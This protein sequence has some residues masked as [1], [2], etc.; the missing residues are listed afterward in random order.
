MEKNIIFVGT[1][2]QGIVLASRMLAAVAFLSGFDVK[3]SEIHGMAQRGGSVIGH[4]RF[5]EKVYSP[6][7][8]AGMADLILALEEMEAL[9]YAHL[10]K[11][12]AFVFLNKKKILPAG[13]SEED[14][15]SDVE[16]RLKKRGFKVFSL[17]G[18]SLAR[19]LGN[20]RVENTLFLGVLSA[21]LPFK[22]S[23]WEEVIKK[24]VPSKS[25]EVNLKA[26][27]K[28]RELGEGWKLLEQKS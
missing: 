6:T 2:G 1:G 28:G 25:L 3:E 20:P 15:P 4:I 23:T 8:P 21:F 26:F 16:E 5:G 19:E 10:L 12:R 11:K 18:E 7:I 22:E 9:R 27:Y 14:Y 17:E 13:L 24:S